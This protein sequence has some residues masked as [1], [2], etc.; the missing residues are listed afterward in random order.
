MQQVAE[1]RGDW[2]DVLKQK[3]ETVKA[4]FGP[5]NPQGQSC[6]KML[7]DTFQRNTMLDDSPLK[8]AYRVGQ[9]ELVSY[10][11]EL[12]EEPNGR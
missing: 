2:R 6:L 8:M 3:S 4:V 9:H 11:K 7:E 5:S 10:I 12:L 1:K